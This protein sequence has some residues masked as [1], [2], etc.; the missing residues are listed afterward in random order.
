MLKKQ[1]V[2]LSNLFCKRDG[3][4]IQ[5]PLKANMQKTKF[6]DSNYKLR[7]ILKTYMQNLLIGLCKAVGKNWHGLCCLK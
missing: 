6:K 3:K 1:D 4:Q 7:P 5:F 2:M